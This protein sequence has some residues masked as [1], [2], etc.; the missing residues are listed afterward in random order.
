MSKKRPK[1][2]NGV[3]APKQPEREQVQE[4]E[5]EGGATKPWAQQA[6]SATEDNEPTDEP[7]GRSG[8]KRSAAR[9]ESRARTGR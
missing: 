6:S 9:E 2:M 5:D 7:R 4:W 3:T 8:G 1:E